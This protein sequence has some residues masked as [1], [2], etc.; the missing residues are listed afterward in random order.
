MEKAVHKNSNPEDVMTA[1]EMTNDQKM[2]LD[3]D[4]CKEIAKGRQ[5][6]KMY[7]HLI[8]EFGDI[9]ATVKTRKGTGLKNIIAKGGK[10]SELITP[11]M[12]AIM[13]T[14]IITGCA[15][16]W[17]AYLNS[18][19]Y[20]EWLSNQHAAPVTTTKKGESPMFEKPGNTT[21]ATLGEEPDKPVTIE[22]VPQKVT[23]NSQDVLPKDNTESGLIVDGKEKTD[24]TPTTEDSNRK[25][26]HVKKFTLS[27][28][29]Q[30]PASNPVSN[31][32]Y[33]SEKDET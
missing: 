6:A 9:Y 25:E 27:N 5:S 15:R 26:P 19:E 16:D 7:C 3:R 17:P 24:N 30:K 21:S 11:N 23:S 4:Y 10:V 31:P 32:R 18:K 2:F 1:T 29:N 13:R 14:I 22:E 33:G 8:L 28:L 12:E 20:K